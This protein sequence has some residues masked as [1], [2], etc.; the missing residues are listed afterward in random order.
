MKE[1]ESDLTV[2]TFRLPRR[3]KP[4]VSLMCLFATLCGCSGE[5]QSGDTVSTPFVYSGYTEPAFDSYQRASMYVPLSD[6]V[7]LA[8]TA[9]IPGDDSAD[10]KFPVL[11]WYMPGH[12]EEIDPATGEIHPAGGYEA[13]EFF[14]SHGYVYVLAEMRGSGASEGV[15]FD[16]SP[17]VGAD[18]RDLVDW[19]GRQSWS[20]GN[21]GM[22]G[23][24]YQGFSQFATA[25]QK[26][27]ALKAIFPE[28]AGFDEYTVMFRPGGILNTAMTGFATTN[29]ARDDENWYVAATGN[30]TRSMLPSVPVIDEDQDGDLADEIPID[31]NGNG[32]FLD[33]GPPVY[34]DGEQRE[35]IYYRASRSHQQN[36]NIS[37]AMLAGAPFR[38][39][40]LPGSSYSFTDIGP[41]ARPAEIADSGIAVYYRGGWF[42]YHAR[43]GTQWFSTL[44]G[45]TPTK[46]MMT[47]AVHAGFPA[48]VG[49]PGVGPYWSYFGVTETAESLNREKLRFFDR[50][51]K[52][53]DNGIDT[54]PP[55][56]LFVPFKGWR[57]EDEWP[58]ARQQ[59]TEFYFRS[60]G[61]LSIEEPL[62]PG[63]DD[64][65]V[66]LSADSRDN[67]ANRWN[68]LA[69][70]LAV[71]MAATTQ[72]RRR[73]SYTTTPLTEDVEVTGH[74]VV[75]VWLSSTANDGDIFVYL[76]DVD[77]DGQAL[78]VTEGALRAN[79]AASQDNDTIAAPQAGI[80]IKPELPWQG[81]RESDYVA[82]IFAD[83][84][85][86]KS[87][88]DLMPTSWTFR[89]GHRIRVSLAG[90]DW[91]TF[92]L[93][94]ALSPSNDPSARDNIRPTL[95]V[96][97]SPAR[98]SNI[99]LPVIPQDR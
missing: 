1:F 26:P 39:S 43:C 25:A 83:D 68:F 14:T 74:P 2:V 59:L 51:L 36:T 48:S 60:D 79:F 40:V 77:E 21:V 3:I 69:S 98:P 89:A 24:S 52:G 70:R 76:E 96:H 55:I 9:F 62:A 17:Q 93:H 72:D 8:I 33:D 84:S 29:I 94:P 58:L 97:R 28:I 78:V 53:I 12:R 57:F 38:D 50:Y 6:G 66:D 87:T 67:G 16:R 30:G 22:I 18:G 32:T 63:T 85:V 4:I 80:D 54:E 47:P 90:A 92:Q 49:A 41:A 34:S 91:P 27:T 71:P 45:H 31:Q 65:A 56:Y 20:N 86:V 75:E 7:N 61:M 37:E 10:E 95:T 81:F 64:Y 5:R 42:D 73:Q 88:L 35:D 82:R 19:L 46:L 99:V 15:R 13:I 11:L 44:H 23:S